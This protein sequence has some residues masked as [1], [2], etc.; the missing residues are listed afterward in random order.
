MAVEGADASNI[1]IISDLKDTIY[2]IR[3]IDLND[4]PTGDGG[5]FATSNGEGNPII[6]APDSLPFSLSQSVCIYQ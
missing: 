4:L 6:V 5:M 1:S 2:R 3:Y